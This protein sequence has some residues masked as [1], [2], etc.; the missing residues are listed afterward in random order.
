[1]RH[2]H[3]HKLPLIE[4]RINKIEAKNHTLTAEVEACVK[5]I[6]PNTEVVMKDIKKVQETLEKKRI[7]DNCRFGDLERDNK[8]LM[9]KQNLSE[10]EHRVTDRIEDVARVL[11]S[12]MSDKNE[13]AKKFR[14]FENR[15]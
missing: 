13:V 5:R 4:D 8:Y 9:K 15:I 3:D 6:P 7:D 1:M 10:L 12:T 14:L 2:A 11:K